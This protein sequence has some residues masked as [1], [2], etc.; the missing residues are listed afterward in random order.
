MTAVPVRPAAY[1]RDA[2]AD[3]GDESGMTG[4]RGM[5]VGWARYLGWPVPVVY[6]DAGPAASAP[7]SGRR[8]AALVKAIAAG[9]HDAVIIP[10]PGAI[11]RDLAQIEAFDR[12]CRQHGVLL[13]CPYGE[14]VT[15]PHGL[16]DVIR[17]V[18]RFTVTEEHLRLLRRA[19]VLGAGGGRRGVSSASAVF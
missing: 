8:Y 18:R 19:R 13:C 15:S 17:D 2:D 14:K 11:G 9:R 7:G 16:F 10:G 6:A 3:P 5:I 12:Y 1:I 4:Y